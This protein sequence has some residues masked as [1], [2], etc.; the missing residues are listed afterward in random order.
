[1]RLKLGLI[2]LVLL[3]ILP[4]SAEAQGTSAPIAGPVSTPL[5]TGPQPRWT[6]EQPLA[7]DSVPSD[8][9]P[10]HWKEGA[11]IGGLSLGL[12]LALLSGS[13]CRDSESGGC[14]GATTGGFLLGA[15]LG[16][17]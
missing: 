11:L 4:S 16:G 3:P 15:V 14:G 1:M 8:I 9:R 12:G 6:M 17:L 13:L 2:L 10:T 7:L 5:L